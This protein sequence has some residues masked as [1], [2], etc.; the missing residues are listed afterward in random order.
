MVADGR[1]EASSSRKIYGGRKVLILSH[2]HLKLIVNSSDLQI[3]CVPDVA[4]GSTSAMAT[5][6]VYSICNIPI[7]T[8]LIAFFKHL[9]CDQLS[10]RNAST[11]DQAVAYELSTY[12]CRD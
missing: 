11:T 4:W 5:R 2:F 12:H 1:V 6:T 3:A 10:N 7:L 9:Q 8:K